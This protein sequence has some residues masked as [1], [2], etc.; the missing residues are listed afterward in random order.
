MPRVTVAVCAYNQAPYV[1]AA[2]NS[3]FD[4]SYEYIDFIAVD[5]HSLDGTPDKIQ[6]LL[7]ATQKNVKFIR[8]KSN[9]GQMAAML[10]ALEASTAPFIVWVDGDDLL[11]PS[12]VETHIRYHLN[13]K[14]AC[15]FTSSN[16]AVIDSDGQIISGT[17]PS[18]SN[19]LVFRP[20][21]GEVEI[22]PLS[23]YDENPEGG[24]LLPKAYRAW[25]WSATSGMMFRTSVI[26]LIRPAR[27]E[28][29]R[30]SGDNYFAR[31]SHVVGGSLVIPSV[32]G[33]YRIHGNNNF[34]RFKI[35]GDQIGGARNSAAQLDAMNEEFAKVLAREPEIIT[36]CIEK[37]DL[38]TLVKRIGSSKKIMSLLLGNKVL[39]KKLSFR[40]RIDLIA[41]SVILRLRPVRDNV[42]GP[43]RRSKLIQVFAW[44]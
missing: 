40:K 4:Q 43:G 24:I 32:L 25:A 26:E 29:I 1:E 22:N 9:G 38:Y 21:K 18:L 14:A 12:F 7:K 20:Q 42:E 2:L 31:F 39:W 30:I 37:R 16:M 36:S 15:A 6:E 41:R 8:R 28:A 34:S 17:V 35:L 23:D 13:A 11:E 27:P 3:A 33:F 44:R 19:S 5:D 10:D